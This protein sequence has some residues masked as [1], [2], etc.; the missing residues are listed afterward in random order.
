MDQSQT[1][2]IGENG[3]KLSGGQQQRV[4]IARALYKDAPILILDEATS[5]L[6]SKAERKIQ[7]AIDALLKDRTALMIAHRLSTIA[8]ADL[9][10][11]FD[12]G[13]IVEQGSHEELLAK[14]G[15]YRGLV[16]AQEYKRSTGS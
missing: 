12:Q 2:P 13:Q 5:A 15:L 16:N 11:V 9:I 14:D 7:L 6:D 1:F 8:N 4:A 3:G 10:L